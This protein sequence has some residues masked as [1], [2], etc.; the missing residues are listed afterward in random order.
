MEISGVATGVPIDTAIKSADSSI[1]NDVDKNVQNVGS[2]VDT[3]SKEAI[4]QP[5][6]NIG[7][8]INVQ[9]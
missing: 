3:E 1:N 5:S 4:S 9:V 6:D 8:N 2:Q 7:S